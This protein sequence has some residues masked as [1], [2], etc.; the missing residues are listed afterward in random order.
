M[1][2]LGFRMKPIL[3]QLRRNHSLSFTLIK[4]TIIIYNKLK[5]AGVITGNFIR[6]TYLSICKQDGGLMSFLY[7]LKLQ[8]YW[9]VDCGGMLP[10]EK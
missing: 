9:A 2:S 5:I 4:Y 8:K 7:N 1:K 3:K 10:Y 6:R